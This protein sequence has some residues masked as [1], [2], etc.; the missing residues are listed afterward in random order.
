[1][2]KEEDE[3]Y[4]AGTSYD[5]S[6]MRKTSLSSLF[7]LVQTLDYSVSVRSLFIF[8]ILEETLRSIVRS[9]ISTT[10]PPMISGLT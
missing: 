5:A 6:W 3:Y 1:M 10:R 4:S 7:L 2:P 9:P 8:A